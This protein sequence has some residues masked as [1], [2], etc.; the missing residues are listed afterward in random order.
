MVLFDQFEFR[1]CEILLSNPS[2]VSERMLILEDL[3]KNIENIAC[4][5]DLSLNIHRYVF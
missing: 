1:F 5:E 4:F 2:Y 3:E